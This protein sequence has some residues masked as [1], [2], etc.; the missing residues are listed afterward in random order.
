MT[1]TLLTGHSASGCGLFP[2]TGEA[3]ID[4]F[5]VMGGERDFEGTGGGDD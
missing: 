1:K 2:D 5:S 3:G 4:D